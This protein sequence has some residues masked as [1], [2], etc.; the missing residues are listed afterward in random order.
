VSSPLF[1]RE[2]PDAVW[3]VLR[4]AARHA[5]GCEHGDE[6]DATPDGHQP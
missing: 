2:L 4:V 5:M 3:D 1:I 6:L